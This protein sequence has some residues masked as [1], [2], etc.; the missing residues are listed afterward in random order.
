MFRLLRGIARQGA[1]KGSPPGNGNPGCGGCG[2]F[3]GGCAL[4]GLL[5]APA[6]TLRSAI[7]ISIPLFLGVLVI[8]VIAKR[9]NRTE[10]KEKERS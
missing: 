8:M 5:G 10:N 4:L 9:I 6:S 2:F 3:L 1:K 7:L